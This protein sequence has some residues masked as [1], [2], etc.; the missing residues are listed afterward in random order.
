MLETYEWRTQEDVFNTTLPQFRT[1]ITLSNPNSK[2]IRTHF[3]HARSPHA[4]AVP[5]LYC[6][7]WP[8]SF[9]E[10]TRIISLLTTPPEEGEVAFHVVCPSIPG[11]GFSDASEDAE[12]GTHGAAEVFAGLMQRL[13]YEKYVVCGGDWGFDVARALAVKEPKRVLGVHTWNPTFSAPTVKGQLMG[14]VKWQVAKLTGARFPSLSFGYLPSEVAVPT[15]QDQSTAGGRPLGPAMHRLF[16][17]RPQTLAF[18]LCDSPIG[19]LAVLLDLVATQGSG[20]SVNARPRSPF[21]DPGELEMQDREYEAARNEHVRS[22]NTVKASQGGTT[23][24]S[25]DILNW[26]MMYVAY[27]HFTVVPVC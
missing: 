14:W 15:A 26:T 3:V 9:I 24:S 19:L 11:F 7:S 2:P 20:S 27:V 25:T 4:S 10:V 6:H 18:S 8:G 16:S 12:F 5:L 1:L 13:G 17:L 21:L 23:W 22:D